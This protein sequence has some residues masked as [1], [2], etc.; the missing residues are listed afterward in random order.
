VCGG[1]EMN[2]LIQESRASTYGRPDRRDIAKVFVASV[3]MGTLSSAFVWIWARGEL[4]VPEA[5]V[6]ALVGVL[7][8]VSWSLR[9][10]FLQGEPRLRESRRVSL[11]FLA[12]AFVLGTASSLQ[13]LAAFSTTAVTAGLVFA[14][15]LAFVAVSTGSVNREVESPIATV[16]QGSGVRRALI[17]YHSAHGGWMRALQEQLASGMQATGWRVDL[18]TASRLSPVDLSSY[19]LLVL[20]TPCYNRGPAMPVAKYLERVGDLR[21]MPVVIVV[22]GFNYTER[23]TAEL[24]ARVQRAHGRVVDEI[25]LWSKRSNGPRYGTSD[26]SEIMRRAG[27]RLGESG[28]QRVA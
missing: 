4:S 11:S 10:G 14:V 28:A 25:E 6:G 22:S 5:I 16:G 18:S 9:D 15:W 17:V 2:T 19:Q 23:A 24:R 26:P 8:V 13:G 27:A 12:S 3:A 21:E 20:G 1:G 7:L